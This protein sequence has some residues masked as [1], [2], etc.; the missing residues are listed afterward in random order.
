[1]QEGKDVDFMAEL[2]KGEL[3][4]GRAQPF[5][6]TLGLIIENVK[7]TQQR[8]ATDA[9]KGKAGLISEAERTLLAFAA[10]NSGEFSNKDAV[11]NAGL[12]FET[13]V[14]EAL[15]QKIHKSLNQLNKTTE[16]LIKGG[17]DPARTEI[18]RNTKILLERAL[19][20]SINRKNALYGNLK[21]YKLLIFLMPREI[22]LINLYL[23]L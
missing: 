8:L 23:R 15:Q 11:V 5:A 12:V 14:T 17:I 18:A 2:L 9:A 4:Q 6:K 3:G 19:K 7:A 1:M 21:T 13:I 22:E 20:D 16:K 10:M